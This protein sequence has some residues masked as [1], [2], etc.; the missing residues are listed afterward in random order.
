MRGDD[1]RERSEELVARAGITPAALAPR[2]VE[3]SGT[4]GDPDFAVRSLPVDDD[5]RAAGAL[6]GEDA[7]F[8]IHVDGFQ[9]L[10]RRFDAREH[11]VDGAMEFRF[12]HNARMI[13]ALAAALAFALAALA[14]CGQKGP[15]KLPEP[16]PAKPF[17]P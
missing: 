13:R 2:E 9:R 7:A 11:G 5:S 3:A 17:A 6:Q 4:R 15:L 10:D 16:P 8:E 12:R 14:G 1:V